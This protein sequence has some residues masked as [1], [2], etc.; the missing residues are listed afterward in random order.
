MPSRKV[1]EAASETSERQHWRVCDHRTLEHLDRPKSSYES[2]VKDFSLP[3]NE[4]GMGKRDPQ[5]KCVQPWVSQ[6]GDHRVGSRQQRPNL[7][8]RR[9]PRPMKPPNKD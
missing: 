3:K 7:E 2:A 8:R 1:R 4:P 6:A 9:C 5:L